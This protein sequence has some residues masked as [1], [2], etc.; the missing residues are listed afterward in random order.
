MIVVEKCYNFMNG[1]HLRAL[2]SLHT[3]HALASE[4]LRAEQSPLASVV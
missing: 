1:Y 4:E 2:A 3:F